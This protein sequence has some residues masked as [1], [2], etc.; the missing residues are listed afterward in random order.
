MSEQR[1]YPRIWRTIERTP[2]CIQPEKLA[3]IVRVLDSIEADEAMAAEARERMEAKAQPAEIRTDDGIAI[4]PVHGTIAPRM[5]LVTALSGGVSADILRSQILRLAE[6]D[7][8]K[9]II[10]DIDSPGG[11]A[12]GIPELGEAVM[13]AR[14][15]K[16]V[17]AVANPIALSA[18]Y[19]IASQASEIVAGPLAEV[20]SIGVFMLHQDQ[21]EFLAKAGIK[22]TLIR[23]VPHK[24]AGNPFEP[25]ADEER[26]ELQRVV[27][28]IDA[29]FHRAV[30]R[31]RGVPASTVRAEF[32][33]GRPVLAKEAVGLRMADRIESIDETLT[34]LSSSQGRAKA[35]TRRPR[36]TAR[37]AES[38]LQHEM[39]L[40]ARMAKPIAGTIV[41]ASGM[42]SGGLTVESLADHGELPG[43]AD[44]DVRDE[45]LENVAVRDEHDEAAAGLPQEVDTDWREFAAAVRCEVFATNNGDKAMNEEL[46]GLRDEIVAH[47]KGFEAK[48]Q[49]QLREVEAKG[50][51]SRKLSAELAEQKDL[52]ES[53]KIQFN[54]IR[55]EQLKASAG[56]GETPS[57]VD[58]LFEDD[59][60]KA[61]VNRGWHQGNVVVNLKGF[62]PTG[63]Q[64]ATITSSA[65]GSATSGILR[66]DRVRP[67]VTA[68]ERRLTMREVLPAS[69]T[70][71]N[72]IEFPKENAFTNVASPQVEGNDKSESSLTFT[73]GTAAVRTIAHWIP[74]SRQ[75]LDDWDQLRRII[76]T[77]MLYGLL[78]KEEAEILSGDNT[79][80][81]LNGLITQ[82]TAYN[83]ALTGTNDTKIDFVRNAIAQLD[84]ADEMGADFVVVNPLDF[85]EM[86]GLKDAASNQGA[87]LS[88]SPFAFQTPFRLYG[89]LLV[90]TNA[91]TSGVFLVGN[92]A[93]AEIFDRQQ[94]TVAIST[95]HSDYFVKNLV[96]I[97][98]EER[99]ALAVYRTGAFVTGN[100]SSASPLP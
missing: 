61:F 9:A 93:Q 82:A 34:R 12:Y 4:V 33:Q 25:L 30:G 87:Y 84:V 57:A 60:F 69:P 37:E 88:G 39:G 31:G 46:N 28:L 56:T 54:Q 21:S 91:I 5:N 44:E 38:I 26:E 16:P 23:S 94:A 20:G 50:E 14:A 58:Q 100:Y 42:V 45:R 52:L 27:N 40:S 17:V 29:D 59:R 62:F 83:T 2:W 63:A 76:E 53:L 1:R 73:I 67:Y 96:A 89:K 22:T 36:L 77:K 85:W 75:V 8:V 74:A 32:G 70:D 49:E 55:E 11:S 47:V 10:L 68:A 78:Y 90:P 71:S 7:A 64:M 98:V 72:A 18:A 79:G 80:V 6:D 95:E 43:V 48:V 97:R 13:S 81:H 66:P 15:R 99:V 35:M 92:S 51:P 3:E 86:V 24:A 19:W 65:V 41:S